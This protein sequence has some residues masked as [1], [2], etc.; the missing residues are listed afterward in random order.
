MHTI[1]EQIQIDAPP[2]RTWGVLSKITAMRAYMP[3]IK[4]VRLLSDRDSGEGAERHCVFEDGVELTERVIAWREG[5]GY[6]LETTTFVGV[7]M[8]SNV[9]TF[10]I[11]GSGAT[12]TVTQSMRY[13]MQG[14]ILAPLMERAA[15]GMMRKALRGALGGLKAHVEGAER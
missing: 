5:A 8:R 7:P 10:A 6:T 11:A 9:I 12:T 15:V 1:E 2:E 3:G 14:W 4:E 13:Q